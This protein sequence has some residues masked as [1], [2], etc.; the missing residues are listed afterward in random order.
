MT[1]LRQ[2]FLFSATLSLKADARDKQEKRIE[3]LRGGMLMGMNLEVVA[4]TYPSDILGDKVAFRR[5]QRVI[6]LTTERVVAAKL[7]EAMVECLQTEKVHYFKGYVPTHQPQDDYLYYFVTQYPGRTLVFV[8]SISIIRRLIAVFEELGVEI[9][10]LHAQMQQRQRLKNLERFRASNGVLLC[11]DVAARG[12]D[13][14]EVKHVIHYQLPRSVDVRAESV[15]GLCT[16][17]LSYMSIDRVV[18]RVLWK[19]V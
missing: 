16:E 2:T 15:I 5:K 3:E 7:D 9:F 18:L 8:N 13:V 6:D 12:L 11:T 10:K 17:S 4:V 19:A 14:P 1:E